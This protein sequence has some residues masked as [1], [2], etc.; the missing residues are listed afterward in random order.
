MKGE[1]TPFFYE[2]TRKCPLRKPGMNTGSLSA[3]MREAIEDDSDG[4]VGVTVAR[5]GKSGDA[6][7]I[8]ESH[9]EI[10]IW[11]KKGTVRRVRFHRITP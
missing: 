1:T 5:P 2:V 11:A 4:V 7:S 6:R 8:R 10:Q 3:V 9:T